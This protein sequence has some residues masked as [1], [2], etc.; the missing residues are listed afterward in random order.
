MGDDYQ[1]IPS[2]AVKRK[3]VEAGDALRTES[4][5]RTRNKLVVS[6]PAVAGTRSKEENPPSTTPIPLIFADLP[7]LDL[8]DD[9]DTDSLFGS[10]DSE[11]I[12]A[13]S[14]ADA[15]SEARAEPIPSI[16]VIELEPASLTAPSIP[17]LT[18]DP[19]LLLPEPLIDEVFAQCMSTYFTNPLTNQIML[20]SRPD[21]SPLPPF[22]SD[23]ISALSGLLR[24]KLSEET[25]DL[26]FAARGRAR[27]AIVNLYEPG[28]GITPHVD[29]LDRFGDGIVGV[30]M[31]SGCAMHFARTGASKERHALYL[32]ARSVIVMCGAAR[33]EWTHGI[34]KLSEDVVL[35]ED[36]RTQVV[37]RGT[38]VSVTFRWLLPGADVVGD[39]TGDAKE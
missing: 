14:S 39:Q 4:G 37:K 24:P 6:I 35:G 7:P 13:S 9:C 31:G 36:G 21:A 12:A 3:L 30:S 16:A 28:E 19:C 5:K 32:P 25:H 8:D 22:L 26:L 38:R 23:L 17:G 20:F 11:P 2:T 29:L 34:E 27:Q 15:P 1:F 18:F 10:L 33:Y